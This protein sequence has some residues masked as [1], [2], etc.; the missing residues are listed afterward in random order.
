M[1][2]ARSAQT[3]LVVVDAL[4]G[5][6]LALM[7]LEHCAVIA[8]VNTLAEHYEGR[9]L[10]LWRWPFWVTGLITNLAAPTFWVV[11]GVSVALFEASRRRRRETEWAITRFFLI[12][13]TA[14]I[15]LDSTFIA[16]CFGLSRGK[17]Y[18]Y[19]FDILSSVGVS[20]SVVSV[21]RL[22][23]NGILAAL[24]VTLL[25][26]YQGLLGYLRPLLPEASSGR[27]WAS[28]WIEY[29]SSAHPAVWF[30]ILGWIGL[31][32]LGVCLGRHIHSPSFQ[33]SRTWSG[34]AL[35]LFAIWAAIRTLRGY[36]NF[37]P[38]DPG[39][40]W[41][42]FLVMSKG[43][44]SLDF[45]TFNLGLAALILSGLTS[46]A[47]K[48]DLFSRPPLVWLVTCGQASLCF[49]VVHNAVYPLIG[50]LGRPLL[51]LG[52]IAR[53]AIIYALGMVVLIPVTSAY[54]KLKT[55]HPESVLKYL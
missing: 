43:P 15:L 20:L 10:T 36:G 37:V 41:Q 44:V 40:P 45:L 2:D 35:G 19:D 9:A 32:G 14:L 33:R 46:L 52:G 7:A 13:A 8:H 12:R 53:Y 18:I 17:I 47:R 49:F 48:P 22:L 51:Q 21:A 5:V 1:K 4:R 26:V 11:A 42:M 16:L 6:A 30:P 24:S 54:R 39:Q 55:R 28:I 23:P 29:T 25:V 3:R 50:V 34:A 31:M 38:Y 27:F